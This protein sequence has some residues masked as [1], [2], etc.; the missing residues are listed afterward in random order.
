MSTSLDQ[1][2]NKDQCDSDPSRENY[3]WGSCELYVWSRPDQTICGFELFYRNG[4]QTERS[5]RWAAAEGYSFNQVD[6][7][8]G[9]PP[10]MM[11]VLDKIPPL[12]TL[13]VYVLKS[14]P[15]IPQHV[16]DVVVARIA[17]AEPWDAAMNGTDTNHD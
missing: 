9:D 7:D 6:D 12:T 16:F 1:L 8:G 14:A 5:L 17:A 4:S 3:R 15:Y 10:T 11:P 2:M 13:R